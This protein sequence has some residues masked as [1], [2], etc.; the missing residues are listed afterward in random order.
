MHRLPGVQHTFAQAESLPHVVKPP[1]G[2]PK[3][4]RPVVWQASRRDCAHE[5]LFFTDVGLLL[6]GSADGAGMLVGFVCNGR[7]W[8]GGVLL[9]PGLGLGRM[10]RG[11]A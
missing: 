4:R 7:V 11:G 3:G 2:A 6:E 1:Q 10:G 8:G 5:I 9:I